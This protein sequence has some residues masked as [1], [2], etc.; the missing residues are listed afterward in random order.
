MEGIGKADFGA[1]W[2]CD[3]RWLGMARR[4]MERWIRPRDEEGKP[5]SK[6]KDGRI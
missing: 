5:T 1:R 6:E 3:L 4:G 2:T